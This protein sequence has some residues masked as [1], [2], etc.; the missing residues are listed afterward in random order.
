MHYY[1]F[2]I[3]DYAKRTRHLT[4]L[5]DLAYRRL[6][7]LYYL[8]ELP[9]KGE[10]K[11]IARLISMRENEG[12]VANVLDDF[13]ICE[14]GYWT[15]KRVDEEIFKYHSKADTARSN[16]KKGGRPKKADGNP[17]ITQ[18]VNLANPAES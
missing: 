12:E 15:N 16:G 10:V 14:G 7:E 1:Q 4:N 13:F 8:T 5:E 3:G 2:N 6:I 9:I 18:P 11:K 17:E